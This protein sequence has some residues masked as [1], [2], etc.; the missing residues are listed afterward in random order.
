MAVISAPLAVFPVIPFGNRN[1]SKTLGRAKSPKVL[2]FARKVHLGWSESPLRIEMET[3]GLRLQIAKQQIG[4]HRR[5]TKVNHSQMC[6]VSSV[7]IAL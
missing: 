5:W 3:L 2:G 1:P 4:S 7:M 6:G